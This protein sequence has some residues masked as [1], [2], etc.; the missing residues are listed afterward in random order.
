MHG[1]DEEGAESL[2]H[3]RRETT[4]KSRIPFRALSW[5]S[6]SKLRDPNTSYDEGEQLA[7]LG[8]GDV[9][10]LDRDDDGVT[11][12]ELRRTVSQQ[13]HVGVLPCGRPRT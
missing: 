8:N 13:P 11:R 5:L 1:L 3:E 7:W 4:R 6:R 2:D 10:G 12:E 9:H